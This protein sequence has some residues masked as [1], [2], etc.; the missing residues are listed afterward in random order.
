MTSLEQ[1]FKWVWGAGM[2][3]LPLAAVRDSWYQFHAQSYAQASSAAH[4][5]IVIALAWAFWSL[6]GLMW[7]QKFN[8]ER[9]AKD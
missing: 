3:M 5:V 6:G 2:A 9:M 4:H 1:S 8:K 7:S